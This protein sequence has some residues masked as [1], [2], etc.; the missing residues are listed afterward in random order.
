VTA[1]SSGESTA[2]LTSSIRVDRVRVCPLTAA[3]SAFGWSRLARI[4]GG[5]READTSR[6]YHASAL[7]FERRLRRA[8]RKDDLAQ[9]RHFH[10]VAIRQL[11]RALDHCDIDAVAP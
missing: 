6:S 11:C 1:S 7:S 10:P 4:S 9:Q 5:P 3:A 8:Y 2:N